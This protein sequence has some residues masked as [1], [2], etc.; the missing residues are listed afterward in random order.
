M[1]R[2]QR[3]TLR[4]SRRAF[5]RAEHA[6]RSAAAAAAVTRLAAFKSGA[7]VAIYLPFDGE[8][9]TAA[10]R[11]AARRRGIKLYVPVITDRRHC[12]M[13]FFPLAGK[14][15]RGAYGIAAPEAKGRPT[16]ARWLSLI[17]VPLVGIDGAGRRL[18]M[19]GGYYDRALEFRRRRHAWKGPTLVGFGFDRQRV[20]ALP[21]D[22]WDVRLDCLATE[23]GVQYFLQQP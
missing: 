17:V 5:N 4:A 6:T 3:K 15:R 8:T 1:K 12:R 18:G 9:D 14:T 7:R 11:T 22:P 23:S 20:E 21:A 10:L 19:G 16:P 13:R 2:T